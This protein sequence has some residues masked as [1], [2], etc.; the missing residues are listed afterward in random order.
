[1][2]DQATGALS[3]LVIGFQ[4][5]AITAATAGF[6]MPFNSSGLKGSR[7]Q[8]TPA[9]MR[10]NLNPTEPSDGNESVAGQIVVPVDSIAMWY[11]LKAAC[12]APTTTGSASPWTHKFKT[13]D[14]AN[15]RPYITIEH[16][17][18]DLA[19][20][21]YFQYLGCKVMSMALSMGEDAEFVATLDFVGISETITTSSFDGSP[22][23]VTMSRLK[24]NQMTLK[25]GGSNI[26]N[27][28]SLSCNIGWKCDNSQ[29][30]I[31]AGGT[32][33]SIPDGVMEV[34][35]E[36]AA[37]FENMILLDKAKNSTESSLEAAFTASADSSLTLKFP[38][39]KYTPNSPGIPGP[40]GIA[41]NL[42]YGAY[43]DN[44]TE[45]T[46][47]QATL[48]NTEEHA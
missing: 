8:F 25:E 47:V 16:Q 30:V 43:Y 17:Y 3:K 26:A 23:T 19:T 37:L 34:K 4:T 35:G 46:S 9:T 36:L 32:L 27:A 18:L 7:N 31:G 13:G 6:V 10:G 22:T 1:M 33:G 5:D 20:P 42:P 24:N 15:L 45:A 21:Q 44:S 38:E 14:P 11:W 12:G 39:I 28:K 2:G 41:I 40:Q 48:I 29:Y